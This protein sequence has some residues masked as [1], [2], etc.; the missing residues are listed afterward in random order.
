MEFR[1]VL[2]DKAK[3]HVKTYMLGYT[4]LQPAQPISLAHYLLHIEEAL[5]N[6][7]KTI[8]ML[9]SIWLDKSP[10]GSGALASTNV[11]LDR[12]RL[13]E[14]LNFK[15]VDLNSLYATSSRDFIYTVA[16]I[17]TSLSVTLSRVAEDFILWSTPYYNYVVLPQDHIAT[18]SIMPQKRNPVTLEIVRAKSGENIGYLTSILSIVNCKPTGYQLDLQEL[19]K[20]LWCIVKNVIS[21]IEILMNIIEKSKFNVEKMMKD[22]VAVSYTHLTLPTN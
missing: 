21:A 4:H 8:R 11:P 14:K 22:C 20:H 13:A 12:V 15:D 9:W 7:Y 5:A 1:R 2:I 18:S 6:Y 19:S 3:E 17:L 10:L 16:S